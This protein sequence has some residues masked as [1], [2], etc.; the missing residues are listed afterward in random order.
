MIIN[1]PEQQVSAA[2]DTLRAM[3]ANLTLTPMDRIMVYQT[4]TINNPNGQ[5][6]LDVSLSL[7]VAARN[8][9]CC[10]LPEL[11]HRLMCTMCA[12]LENPW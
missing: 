9:Y 1:A 12:M 11:Q 5:P 3:L 8:R 7:R 4:R 10:R 6:S 2:G